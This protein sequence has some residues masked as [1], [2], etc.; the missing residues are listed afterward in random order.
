MFN[1]V[2]NQSV[3]KMANLSNISKKFLRD[4]DNWKDAPT[5]LCMGGDL[6]ALSWCCK[7]GYSLTF[8]FKCLRD[9]TLKDLGMSQEKF[10]ENKEK[11]SEENGWDA[12]ESCFGSLSYCCMRNGGCY[13]RD[14]ALARIYSGMSYEKA[15]A[16]YF[17]LKRILAKLLLE[18]VKNHPK[19]RDL[20]EN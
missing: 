16:E 12:P 19:T 20:I 4:L 15:K 9:E 10:M 18:E 17:R 6:R 5:P 3:V 13:R 2:F 11:F 1:L 8:G 14:A 7:P